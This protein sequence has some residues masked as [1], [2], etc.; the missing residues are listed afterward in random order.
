[1]VLEF[2]LSRARG[3]DKGFGLPLLRKLSK[4]WIIQAR[5][6]A[7][8]TAGDAEFRGEAMPKNVSKIVGQH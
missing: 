1:M 7:S 5:A 2:T 8:K 4:S 6:L 3:I